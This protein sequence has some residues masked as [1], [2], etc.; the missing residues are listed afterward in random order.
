MIIGTITL[1]SILFFGGGGLDL[2]AAF[3]KM[4]EKV[5]EVVA[6]ESRAAD[7]HAALEASIHEYDE[8]VR[9]VERSRSE[10]RTLDLRH[11]PSRRDYLRAFESLMSA[12]EK[13]EERLLSLRADLRASTT[14][15]E[16]NALHEDLQ[17]KVRKLTE[18]AEKQREKAGW[19]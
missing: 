9:E 7:A 5:D 10:I 4:N 19:S 16:W 15:E 12:W 3:E 17:K 11:D 13:R 8:F 14:R 1:I 18:D 2:L 6:D